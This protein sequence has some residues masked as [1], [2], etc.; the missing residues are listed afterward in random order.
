MN[1]YLFDAS[2]ILNIVKNLKEEALDVLENNYT[3]NL[4][5]YEI[6]NAIWKDVHIFKSYTLDDGV[7]L[8]NIIYNLLEYMHIIDTTNYYDEILNVAERLSITFYDASYLVSAFKRCLLLVTDDMRILNA[9]KTNK[10]FLEKKYSKC[11]NVM[12]SKD[13]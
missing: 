5:Y 4:A 6:G 11:V 1:A 7:Y 3:I 9:I 10:N 2:S 8:L 13:I 12:S